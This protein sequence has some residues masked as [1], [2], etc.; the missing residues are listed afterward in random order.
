MRSY[1]SLSKNERPNVD[2][3]YFYGVNDKS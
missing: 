2:L 1:I 3:L